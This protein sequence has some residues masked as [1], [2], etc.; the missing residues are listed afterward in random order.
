MGRQKFQPPDAVS[1]SPL[2]GGRWVLA[3]ALTGS[4]PWSVQAA[5]L[6]PETRDSWYF[7]VPWPAAAAVGAGAMPGKQ[8]LNP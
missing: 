5:A 4:P 8:A 2:Q 3:Y 6:A 1:H 7:S